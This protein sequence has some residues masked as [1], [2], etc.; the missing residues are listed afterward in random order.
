M[1]TPE[2]CFAYV[3][4]LRYFGTNYSPGSIYIR[5]DRNGYGNSTYYF[6]DT[7]AEALFRHT[8]GLE[9]KRGVSASGAHSNL[10]IYTDTFSPRTS[11]SMGT[12]VAGHLCWG[13]HGNFPTYYTTNGWLQFHGDSA[14]FPIMSI[15]SFNGQW[16]PFDFQTS[17]HFWFVKNAFFG[18]DYQFTPIGAVSHLYEPF[19]HGVSDAY[20]Y[21][22]WWELGKCFARCAW[23]SRR[24]AA[25]QACGDPFV[26]K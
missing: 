22:G 2:D 9:A 25:F 13:Y 8:P 7:R 24:T 12:N 17:Y 23:A 11:P 14:W 15:E 19:V 10:V 5:P 18:Q 4:K 26:C 20:K 6:D 1:R 21:F 16:E 3:D